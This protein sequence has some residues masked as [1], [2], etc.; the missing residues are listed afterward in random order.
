MSAFY[1]LRDVEIKLIQKFTSQTHQPPFLLSTLF[2]FILLIAACLSDYSK[3]KHSSLRRLMPP[4]FW[5]ALCW[6]LW[7]P[8]QQSDALPTWAITEGIG[9]RGGSRIFFRRGCTRLLPYFNTNKPHSFFCRI[10]VV[11]ENRRSSQ[12]GVRTPCT[13][14]LDPPLGRASRL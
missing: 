9:S 6:H 13:L 11:L 3:L 4:S 5:T 14:P 7:F 2:Y 8:A 1:Y 10:P 12:G